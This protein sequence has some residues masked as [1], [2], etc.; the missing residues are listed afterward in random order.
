MKFNIRK[1]TFKK[2]I[3]NVTYAGNTFIILLKLLFYIPL[4]VHILI[5][6]AQYIFLHPDHVN[7]VGVKIQ[8]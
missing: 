4:M 5:D 3:T 6:L 1:I 2:Q 7:H 8:L